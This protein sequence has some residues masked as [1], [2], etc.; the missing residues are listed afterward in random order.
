MILSENRYSLFG[1][2]PLRA[3]GPAHDAAGKLPERSIAPGEGGR[4]LLLVKLRTH[5]RRPL[6]G[7]HRRGARGRAVS[8]PLAPAPPPP[9]APPPR[10][11]GKGAPPP[12]PQTAPPITPPA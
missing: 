5:R 7:A 12:A 9:R 2:M 4:L 8:P 1:I 3:V 6:R 11:R 10:R